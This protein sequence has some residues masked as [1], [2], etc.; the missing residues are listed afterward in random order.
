MIELSLLIVNYNSW[1]LCA[2]AVRSFHQ[3][4]PTGMTWEVVV[5]DNAS[6][7]RDAAAEADLERVL[8]QVG[9]RL[10]R[11]HENGGYSKGMNLAFAHASGRLILV[12]NPDV[13]F[14]PSCVQA[15]ADYL[16]VH[17]EA[18]AVAPVGYWD[19]GLDGLLPP[20]IL[21][22][23]PDLLSLA[24]ADVSPRWSRRYAARRTQAALPIW[25]ADTPV[26]L[27]MLSGCCFLMRRS[28]IDELG[29]FDERF[30]LYYEDTDLSMRLRRAGLEIVQV[31][32]A[33]I[34]HLYNRSGQTDHGEAMERYW[35]SR[36]LYYRKWYGWLGGKLYDAVRWFLQTGWARR[37]ATLSP[38][39]HIHD[40]GTTDDK[41][42][43]RF[44]YSMQRYLVE[45]ALDAHFFLACGIFGSGDSWTPSD[46][47][48]QGFGPTTFFWRVV[49]ISDLRRPKLVGVYRH[50]LTYPTR[51]MQA[52][53]AGAGS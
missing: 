14:K 18:G 40:L 25:L 43:L 8:D 10:I 9:G 21:P 32:E 47:L 15:L 19:R 1:K 44:P 37:R 4:A 20:N 31:P 33:K 53:S 36:R 35:R 5:V 29:L 24:L 41:P 16:D 46:S 28:T 11:H 50:T 34:V 42:V 52:L 26:N 27:P 38:Q 7:L 2:E 17:P 51:M 12:S 30:P 22:T 39:E 48:F 49:D 23:I 45:G 13:V 6:P 3:H